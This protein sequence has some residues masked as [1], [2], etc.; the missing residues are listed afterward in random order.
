MR[1]HQHRPKRTLLRGKCKRYFSRNRQNQ[2]VRDSK[3]T[4]QREKRCFS[5]RKHFTAKRA[6]FLFSCSL[7][8]GGH[9]SFGTNTMKR[10]ALFVLFL[11]LLFALSLL[12]YFFTKEERILLPLKLTAVGK[13]CDNSLCEQ[14]PSV[15]FEAVL[16]GIPCTVLN[17]EISPHQK[18]D[19]ITGVLYSSRLSSDIVFHVI[20]L[21]EKREGVFY[22]DGKYLA[23][24]KKAIFTS[25][26]WEQ[27]VVFLSIKQ[28]K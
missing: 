19:S 17:Y 3:G 27:T 4:R 5:H 12:G 16:D 24:G 1:T 26:E 6:Q 22:A 10:K 9:L 20:L 7:R 23:A 15:P 14:L 28:E 2:T 18:R 21:G 25:Q 11:L 13:D 8:S